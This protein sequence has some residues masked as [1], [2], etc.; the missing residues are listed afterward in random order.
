MVAL[1]VHHVSPKRI[2][3]LLRGHTSG[4]GN[5]RKWMTKKVFEEHLTDVPCGD[6]WVEAFSNATALCFCC[7]DEVYESEIIFVNGS[8]YCYKCSVEDEIGWLESV[9]PTVDAAMKAI[10]RNRNMEKMNDG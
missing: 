1:I 5:W 6:C 10:R 9:K 2:T 4:G 8:A 3:Y 7:H